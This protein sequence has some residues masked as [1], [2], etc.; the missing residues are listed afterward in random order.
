MASIS[1]LVGFL[2]QRRGFYDAIV[3][4]RPH[5]MKLF[6]EIGGTDKALIGE[7]VVIFDAEA[8]FATREALRHTLQGQ[9]MSPA[10]AAKLLAEEMAL[11]RR[12]SVVLAVSAAADVTFSLY[13]QSARTRRACGT[14]LPGATARDTCYFRA[15]TARDPQS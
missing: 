14:G 3:V 5:N 10:D 7:A 6:V 11:A 8:I 13:I 15:L 1:A 2:E 12:A 4:S 9:P